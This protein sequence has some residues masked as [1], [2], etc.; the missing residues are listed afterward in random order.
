MQP[1]SPQRTSRL[2]ERLRRIQNKF[3]PLTDSQRASQT[4]DFSNMKFG[5][6]GSSEP[7]YRPPSMM[8]RS[9]F[10]APSLTKDIGLGLLRMAGSAATTLETAP[11]EVVKGAITEG[12]KGALSEV[13]EVFDQPFT[14]IV[15]PMSA[16]MW[17]TI[18]N[19]P[20]PM[21]GIGPVIVP[22]QLR[23]DEQT[24][25]AKRIATWMPAGAIFEAAYRSMMAGT[26]RSE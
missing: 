20:V 3:G 18:K 7:E 11:F 25:E 22:A 17:T 1:M 12:W 2:Q 21:P 9:I 8:E 6:G 5:P 16:S 23:I 10:R 24:G 19:T 4:I 15:K 26:P 13:G 14:D